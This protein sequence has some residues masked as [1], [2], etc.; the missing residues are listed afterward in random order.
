MPEWAQRLL[1]GK[2]PERNSPED[3]DFFGW[4]FCGDTVVGLPPS[5]TPEGFQIWY[6]VTRRHAD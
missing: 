1:E 2:R 5:D 6:R 3:I 4:A